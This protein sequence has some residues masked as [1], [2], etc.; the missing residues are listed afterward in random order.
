VLIKFVLIKFVLIEFVLI[1]FEPIAPSVSK[2]PQ[3]T[4]AM[5]AR[6]PRFN[7]FA[8]IPWPQTMQVAIVTVAIVVGLE[9]LLIL[10]LPAMPEGLATMIDGALAGNSKPSL[11]LNLA[12]DGAIGALAVLIYERWKVMIQLNGNT[13]WALVGCLVLTLFIRSAL[14]LKVVVCELSELSAIA[15]LLGVF[16]KGRP[17]W[18]RWG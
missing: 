2:R 16:W 9:Q 10:G 12:I 17:Y 6:R 3:Q 1:E 8:Q 13:L 4:P 18:K 11:L 7:K 14:P 5:T 15:M